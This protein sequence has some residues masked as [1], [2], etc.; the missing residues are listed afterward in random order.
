[1]DFRRF[2]AAKITT[3]LVPFINRLGISPDVL[4]WI[5]LLITAGAAAAIAT[6][7]LLLGGL[8]V[9]FSGLFDILDGALARY[10]N[11]STVFGAL[12]DSTFDRL[13]EGL[14]FLGL[15]I[16]YLNGGHSLEIV[17]IVVVL[18]CSFLISYIRAR[19]EGLG[20][21]CKTGLFTR[22]ERVILLALGL[23]LNQ[24]LIAL[25][26]LAVFTV[27]T[28]IQRLIHVWQQTKTNKTIV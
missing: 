18:V 2:A 28:V 16:L 19:S 4:T 26:L 7:Y 6:N 15:V 14:L 3:P 13:S 12:L 17:L 11:K 20:I 1:M 27:V 23:L 22:T 5:G 21:E 24:I 8:L 25:I 9:L 10:S